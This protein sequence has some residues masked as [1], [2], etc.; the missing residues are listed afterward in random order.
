[1]YALGAADLLDVT[2]SCWH[3]ETSELRLLTML[4]ALGGHGKVQPSTR[5][6]I[7]EV[8]RDERLRSAM[9]AD[10]PEAVES[11]AAAEAMFGGPA[12]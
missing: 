11:S 6:L 7:E 1:M 5:T 12:G 4:S 10:A 3:D 9:T 2:D 8:R